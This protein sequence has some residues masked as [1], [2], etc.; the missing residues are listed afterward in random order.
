MYVFLAHSK[1]PPPLSITLNVENLDPLDMAGPNAA[2]PISTGA[3][4]IDIT[5]SAAG[6][7]GSYSFA[8]TTQELGDSGNILAVLAAGTTNAA[9][10]DTL[11]LRSTA[12]PGP[13][14]EVTYRLTCTVTD[15]NSDTA[16]VSIDQPVVAI[17]LG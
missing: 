10:Y 11:T 16:S 5:A 1:G 3:G 14:A 6:G 2:H 9:Q 4:Q 12:T 7:D 13:P 17:N 15:G 8:W